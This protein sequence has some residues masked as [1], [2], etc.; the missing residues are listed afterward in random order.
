MSE[1][2]EEGTGRVTGLGGVSFKTD[3][4]N[5]TRQ[6]YAEHLGLGA[7]DDDVMLFWWRHDNDPD[8]RGHTVWGPSDKD[9]EYFGSDTSFMFN[10]RVDDLDAILARLRNEGVEVIDKREDSEFGRFGWIVDLDGHRVELW[11]PPKGS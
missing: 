8:R 5:A 9:S 10:Y 3:D 6:W 11:E 2:D 7:P 1:A 4:T